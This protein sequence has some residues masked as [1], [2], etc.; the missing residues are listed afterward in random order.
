MRVLALLCVVL[1]L[2]AVSEAGFRCGFLSFLKKDRACRA[3]CWVLG[4]TTGRCDE[5]ANCICSEEELDVGDKIDELLGD[6]DVIEYVREKM[7]EFGDVVQSWDLDDAVPTS[8]CQLSDDDAV[9]VGSCHAIGRVTGE[10]NE[11]MTDC[12][13]SKEKVT[14]KQYATC[15][16]TSICSVY[17]QHKKYQSGKCVGPTGWDCKCVSKDD[18]NE[19]IDLELENEEKATDA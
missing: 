17:C 18:P 1:G 3:S 6:V 5:D 16:D 19:L 8:R 4:H 13:C 15:L 11:A 9:C 10:C 12:T 7:R 2:V 14:A